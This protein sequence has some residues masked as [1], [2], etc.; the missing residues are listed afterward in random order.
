MEEDNNGL[1]TGEQS[2]QAKEVKTFKEIIIM[3]MS[4]CREEGQKEM[5][6]GGQIK[7]VFNGEIVIK[8]IPNQRKIYISCVETLNNLLK[9]HYDKEAQE[10]IPELIQMGNKVFEEYLKAYLEGE[11]NHSYLEYAQTTRSIHPDAFYYEKISND[12]ELKRVE[13][14]RI[15]FEELIALYYR[16]RELS[17]KR[18]LGAY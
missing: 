3:A 17:N 1:Y 13:I 9:Y 2:Y 11:T 15:I 7:E 14:Y 12:V 10:T 6:R 8:T 4:K 18:M 5:V 16:K